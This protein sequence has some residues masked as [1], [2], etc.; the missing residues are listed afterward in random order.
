MKI[1]CEGS[2][3]KRLLNTV[4]QDCEKESK[5]EINSLVADMLIPGVMQL[6]PGN[7]LL[8]LLMATVKYSQLELDDEETKQVL[9]DFVVDGLR[10]YSQVADRILDLVESSEDV[11]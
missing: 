5:H 1:V 11:E 6:G 4:V 7:M 3:L 10:L 2:D 9:E 8:C